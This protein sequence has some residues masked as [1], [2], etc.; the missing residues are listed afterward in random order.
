METILCRQ[1]LERLQ[2]ITD[3]TTVFEKP[4]RSSV[5]HIDDLFEPANRCSYVSMRTIHG[6]EEEGFLRPNGLWEDIASSIQKLDPDNAD[7][8]AHIK[9]EVPD[10]GPP[11]DYSI[12][13]VV[14]KIE[15]CGSPSLHMMTPPGAYPSYLPPNRL[16][17]AP[18]PTPPTSEPG[19]PG[20]PLQGPPRRTPPPPYPAPDPSQ[21]TKTSTMP[22]ILKFNRRNNPELEKRRVHHCDFHGKCLFLY[23]SLFNI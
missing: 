18:P 15:L 20:A 17:Y 8:L 7:M 2:R 23:F 12:P 10:T 1:E 21:C 16:M 22:M 3:E 19:S 6:P 5:S 4:R 11:D 14:P 13:N 9:T